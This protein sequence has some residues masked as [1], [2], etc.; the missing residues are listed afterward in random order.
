[1]S[2]RKEILETVLD[3]IALGVAKLATVTVAGMAALEVI[4][5]GLI[6]VFASSP[7][8]LAI[9][10]KRSLRRLQSTEK[11]MDKASNRID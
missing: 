9:R 11:A 3:S 10:V 8:I 7:L 4:A 6:A 2:A 5:A 1:M